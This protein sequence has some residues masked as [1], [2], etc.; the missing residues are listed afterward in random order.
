M[1]SDWPPSCIGVC[2]SPIFS[3]PL[4]SFVAVPLVQ[5]SAQAV[6]ANA[7]M[8]W[9]MEWLDKPIET[10]EPSAPKQM[11]WLTLLPTVPSIQALP[12]PV[13]MDTVPLEPSVEDEEEPAEDEA[14][15]V[16][17]EVVQPLNA[18]LPAQPLLA[19]AESASDTGTPATM[20]PR[21]APIVPQPAEKQPQ[22]AAKTDKGEL[23]WAADFVVAEKAQEPADIEPLPQTPTEPTEPVSQAKARP[24]EPAPRREG[25]EPDARDQPPAEQRQV[26]KQIAPPE[27]RAEPAEPVRVEAHAP[28]STKHEAPIAEFATPVSVR[29]QPV[30]PRVAPEAPQPPTVGAVELDT[31]RPLRPAQVATLYVDVP[32]ASG[33]DDAGTIRLAVTQRGEQVNVRLRSW[34]AGAAP[35]ENERMQPLL[36]SLS[37]QGYEAAK[38]SIDQYDDRGPQAVEKLP[39]KPLAAAEAANSSNDQQSFQNA[40]DRQRKNQERQQQAFLVRRQTQN[41]NTEQFDLQAQLDAFNPSPQQGA[42]R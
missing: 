25:S 13:A 32:S 20:E 23:I 40:D 29:P 11:Q 30:S 24:V 18:P 6:A 8:N 41:L 16:T 1:I 14:T 9:L 21:R 26:E 27:Q 15:P 34:D 33:P 12:E 7:D 42:V 31:A 3:L 22:V 38:K 39:E 19:T 5:D 36:Q 10:N 4:D 17:V 37:E 28:P 35:I 2:V